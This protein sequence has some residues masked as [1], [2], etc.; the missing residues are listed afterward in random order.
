M[1]ETDIP[2]EIDWLI[3]HPDGDV[4]IVGRTG[5]G[6]CAPDDPAAKSWTVLGQI[7]TNTS[8]SETFD[9]R[10]FAEARANEARSTPYHYMEKVL[11]GLEIHD[12]ESDMARNA[13]AGERIPDEFKTGAG[14]PDG[15]GNIS[16]RNGDD[17]S[18]FY[19][20]A[21]FTRRS[22]FRRMKPH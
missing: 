4:W 1:N 2:R 5:N 17:R 16:M 20:P 7:G 10:E 12:W 21:N 14:R 19:R 11:R 9:T 15:R 6:F 8:F 13:L 3:G 22:S 18:I